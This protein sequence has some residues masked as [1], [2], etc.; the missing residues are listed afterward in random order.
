MKHNLMISLIHMFPAGVHQNHTELTWHWNQFDI[1]PQAYKASV[2]LYM[3][4]KPTCNSFPQ[5]NEVTLSP[6]PSE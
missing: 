3:E 6:W 1:S 4:I 5:F 2:R